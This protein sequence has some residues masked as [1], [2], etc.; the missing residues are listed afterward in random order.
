MDR[1]WAAISFY[2]R[3]YCYLLKR[4]PGYITKAID[5]FS[6]SQECF[7]LFKE[8]AVLCLTLSSS[9][10]DEN[11]NEEEVNGTASQFNS[12]CQIINYFEENIK[13]SLQQLREF[14]KT[15]KEATAEGTSIFT[16]VLGDDN[17]SKKIESEIY[18]FWEMGL[19]QLIFVKERK[20]FCWK[21][22]L[23]IALGVLQIA[24]GAVIVA[25][26]AGILAQL[27]RGLIA[28]GVNDIFTGA[29]AVWKNEI[30]DGRKSC[31]HSC[32]CRLF[33]L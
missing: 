27:G 28:E 8:E 21:G 13:V 24:V 1:K 31:Q 20:P 14:Q 12:R 5:D 32:I 11:N 23:V 22:M 19:T 17:T 10:N 30:V 33:W 29:Y 15:N 3:A 9:M 7:A 26:T 2:N 6:K 25:S 18:V 16:I 4:E